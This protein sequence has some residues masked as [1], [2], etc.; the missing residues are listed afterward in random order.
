MSA[1]TELTEAVGI[2][3]G[4]SA[5]QRQ[6]TQAENFIVLGETLGFIVAGEFQ[7]QAVAAL[8]KG[9]QAVSKAVETN[10]EPPL[11]GK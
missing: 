10:I 4:L 8:A 5:R 7:E 2:Q 3:R 9:I 6:V 1:I 11:E